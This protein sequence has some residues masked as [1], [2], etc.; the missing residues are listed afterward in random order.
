VTVLVLYF[1][2]VVQECDLCHGGVHVMVRVWYVVITVRLHGA[3]R[4]TVFKIGSNGQPA[5]LWM[6][7]SSVSFWLV[8]G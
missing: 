3:S 1:V 8:E 5:W 4:R 7:A 2:E 6:A